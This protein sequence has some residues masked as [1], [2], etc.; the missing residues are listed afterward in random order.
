MRNRRHHDFPRVDARVARETPT[1]PQ[2]ERARCARSLTRLLDAVAQL[3]G[4]YSRYAGSEEVTSLDFMALALGPFSSDQCLAT[5]R[6]I[7][8]A[9]SD[10]TIA[11]SSNSDA[12]KDFANPSRCCTTDVSSR[13]R[14]PTQDITCSRGA[15][16]DLCANGR[17]TNQNPCVIVIES[18]SN[19]RR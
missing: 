9:G 7:F 11:S 13:I 17:Y 12:T 15:D 10:E 4:L 1:L 5:L 18:R 16:D 3:R 19:L 6:A 8:H 14:R 2:G